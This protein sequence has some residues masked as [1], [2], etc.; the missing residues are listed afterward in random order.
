[1]RQPVLI[2]VIG[3]F[4]DDANEELRSRH[5]RYGLK[6]KE[7]SADRVNHL[8]V[9]SKSNYPFGYVIDDRDGLRIKSI[10][11]NK[12]PWKLGRGAAQSVSD[13][14]ATTWIAGNPFRE[15]SA[16]IE[17]NRIKP[18][19]LQIQA[20]GSFGLLQFSLGNARD[21][22]RFLTAQ[23]KL[24]QADSIRAVSDEQ[25]EGLITRFRLD[26]NKCFTAPVPINQDFLNYSQSSVTRHI[27]PSV[28]FV[29]RVHKERGLKLWA[30]LAAEVAQMGS[31]VE[32]HV[33]GDGPHMKEFEAMLKARIC[34]ENLFFHGRLDGRA[35]CEAISSLSV[36]LNACGVESYGRAMLEALSLGV[37][38]VSIRSPG[39]VSLER[40]FGEFGIF[41]EPK[42]AIASKMA[43]LL[44]QAIPVNVTKVRSLLENS[45]SDAV[46]RLACSWL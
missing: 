1:M 9:L 36:L 46:F 21:T 19:L 16:C 37:P 35:L 3:A 22:A 39:G 6:V 11:P 44:S 15:A 29:G 20:H 42:N 41:L 33:I 5:A 30:E 32:F 31:T 7:L 8:L 18:G 10:G 12:S 28:G 40:S 14:P 23:R 2:D 24:K 45:N 25:L 4:A 38:S 26:R 17:A 34:S 43:S 13:I 27:T